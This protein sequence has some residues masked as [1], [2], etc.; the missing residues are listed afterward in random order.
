MN[1][2]EKGGAGGR[3]R[4]V[5]GADLERKNNLKIDGR[6]RDGTDP[7]SPGCRPPRPRPLARQPALA[8]GLHPFPLPPRLQA[9]LVP[10]HKGKGRPAPRS[11]PVL[12]GEL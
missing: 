10:P 3:E 12:P 8:Q 6:P 11:A 5:W 2:R 1:E 7:V 4:E 9:Y